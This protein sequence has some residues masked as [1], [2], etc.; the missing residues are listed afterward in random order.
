VLDSG[1]KDSNENRQTII[2][3][4]HGKRT[5]PVLKRPK[6]KVAMNEKAMAM[7]P[8]GNGMESVDDSPTS[9]QEDPKVEPSQ[10]V[11]TPQS[12]LKRRRR[13]GDT[14]DHS[15]SI[16]KQ[17][18]KP[19]SIIKLT[20]LAETDNNPFSTG[21]VVSRKYD[22]NL[23][24]EK[25]LF[26]MNKESQILSKK[27]TKE[28]KRLH[29]EEKRKRKEEKAERKRKRREE[30]TFRDENQGPNSDGDDTDQ[31]DHP[32]KNEIPSTYQSND[33]MAALSQEIPVD[34]PSGQP[35]RK[36]GKERNLEIA[37]TQELQS[38]IP[39]QNQSSPKGTPLPE[40]KRRSL[41]SL[42]SSSVKKSE[43]SGTS[44]HPEK[45]LG[46]IE[47]DPDREG[48]GEEMP[49]KPDTDQKPKR[50]TRQ[51]SNPTA[52]QEIKAI[53]ESPTQKSTRTP[54]KKRNRQISAQRIYDSSAEEEPPPVRTSKRRK[55]GDLIKLQKD[56][57][58]SKET[59]SGEVNPENQDKGIREFTSKEDKRLKQVISQYRKVF[60]S[61]RGWK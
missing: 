20:D 32:E 2:P 37:A 16:S 48:S 33:S 55:V 1:G 19:N 30:K 46:L 9:A 25:S 39:E 56:H 4:S 13:N 53:S 3:G 45:L 18:E 35:S 10:S 11:A 22:L 52:N 6:S 24:P 17:Q 60:H 49:T 36:E 38:P 28:M 41:L 58:S 54:R 29:K 15:L 59:S 50:P 21:R 8:P 23:S 44:L 12:S 61:L 47:Q 31:D 5:S 51:T 26:G 42:K 40:P 57:A 14:V 34:Q 43:Q 7:R 27:Q